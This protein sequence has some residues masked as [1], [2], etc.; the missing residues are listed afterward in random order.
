[1]G[2]KPG[3]R[4][5]FGWWIVGV[6]LLANLITTG[7]HF[8]VFNVFM[9][10]L[11][12]AR[13]WTREQ[14]NLGLAVGGIVGLFSQLIH[15]TV[16]MRTGPRVYMG[17]GA[18]ISGFTFMAM[19]RVT[20]IYAF[21]AL[22]VLLFFSNGAFSGIVASSAVNSWFVKKRGRALGIATMGISLAGMVL[23]P[24]ARAL[25]DSLGLEQAFFWLGV[26]LLAT[27]PLSW[28]V[29]R[30]QPEEYG[31]Y[32]D[33]LDEPPEE[34][35]EIPLGG[36]M[37]NP[38]AVSS[39]APVAWPVAKL[40]KSSAFWMV[41]F[42]FAM[43]MAGV[44]GVMS[45]MTPRFMDLGFDKNTAVGLLAAAALCG[46]AGKFCWG[47][48]C[49]VFEARRVACVMMV[50]N[51]AGIAI[52]LF[53]GSLGLPGAVAFALVYG[54]GM[55]GVLATLPVL[56]ADMFGRLAFT[57]VLRFM[58]LFLILQ[59]AGFYIMGKS[60]ALTGSYDTAYAVFLVL[61]AVGAVMVALA[62]RPMPE[63]AG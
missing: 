4:V 21:S 14:I 63:K 23:P 54:F 35:H 46:A 16:V 41:G 32:P 51:A 1:M 11:C 44:V 43:A 19:G 38:A 40:V 28:I 47:A 20:D 52:G 17:L 3:S 25:N 60:T 27:A 58:A 62:R 31:L 57:S 12:D 39:K 42:S 6:A 33:G 13:G 36:L 26:M 61:N 10:P 48:L 50:V 18:V 15:G 34:E 37:A 45:Q 56:V 30:N 24:V 49:D 59:N 2:P 9:D 55:G 53:A 5:F 7:T 22:Y 8:Y 29:I